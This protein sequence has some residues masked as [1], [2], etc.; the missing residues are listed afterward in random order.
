M[1]VGTIGS[2]EEAGAKTVTLVTNAGDTLPVNINNINTRDSDS[3]DNEELCRTPHSQVVRKQRL[4]SKLL[5]KRINLADSPTCQVFLPEDTSWRIHETCTDVF[6]VANEISKYS[7]NF[8]D[9]DHSNYKGEDEE[10]GPVIISVMSN[11]LDKT[12]EMIIR[13][14][15]GTQSERLSDNNDFNPKDAASVL[16]LAKIISPDVAINN[17]SHLPDSQELIATYD[18]NH[19][20][21]LKRRNYT[22]GVLYQKPGQSS[23]QEIFGNIGHCDQFERFTSLLGEFKVVPEHDSLGY[24]VRTEEEL[25]LSVKFYVLT[26]L[27]HST[28]DSQQC[29]RKARIGNC[30][31]SLVF[32]SGEATFSPEIIT[33]Q[34]LHVYI[35]IQP[36][37]LDKYK[38]SIVS[39]NGV[40][41]FGPEFKQYQI[42][43]EDTFP[44][45]LSKLVNAEQAAYKTGKLAVLRKNYRFAGLTQI[46]QKPDE[47][48]E[49]DPSR[50]RVCN[51]L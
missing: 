35:V 17:L 21:L 49:L 14:S 51:L 37:D 16:N 26:K 48:E 44:Q 6:S 40:P 34:F 11:E 4:T 42:L 33:S 29:Q 19:H 8:C 1:S 23:E 9:K 47:T 7:E 18:S 22:I 28:T 24:Y 41:D 45:F 10:G 43:N 50:W 36:V 13:T 5:K 27:P 15:N 39:K 25:S 3:D 32:Q 12:T 31:V 38:I 2:T 46:L 20:Q 30:V